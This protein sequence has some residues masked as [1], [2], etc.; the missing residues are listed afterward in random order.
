MDPNLE[1][2]QRIL[3]TAAGAPPGWAGHVI[4]LGAAIVAAGIIGIASAVWQG[5]G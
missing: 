2:A 3:A 1:I 4:Y 5:R